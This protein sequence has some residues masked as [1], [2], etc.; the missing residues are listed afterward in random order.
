MQPFKYSGKE[1]ETRHGIGWYDFGAR[2]Y[3][4]DV[5]RWTTMDPLSEKYYSVS[6]YAF[7]NN[8]PVNF[9]DPD[10]KKIYFAAGVSDTFKQKFA[11]T[12]QFM[13]SKG[14]AVDLATLH[15]SDIV[16]YIAEIKE[17]DLIRGEEYSLLGI[18]STQRD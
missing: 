10:G 11:E 2:R 5:A 13:N 8:N 14:T 6:P 9:V 16:Y 17:E 3:D 7:C 4:H 18:L 15:E 12:I 1:I